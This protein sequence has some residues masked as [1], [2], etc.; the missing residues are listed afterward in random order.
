[1]VV[2]TFAAVVVVAFVE[3]VVVTEPRVVVVVT[4]PRVVVLVF[5]V[6][7]VDVVP[8]PETLMQGPASELETFFVSAL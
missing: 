7:V 3:V 5:F 8:P 2:G 4:E 1:M 6:L